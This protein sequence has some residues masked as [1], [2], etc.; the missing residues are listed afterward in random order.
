MTS[1]K[2]WG[3]DTTNCKYC[4]VVLYVSRNKDNKGITDFKE[5]RKS[6]IC[7]EEKLDHYRK[8]FINFAEDGV[9]GEM[10]RLYI[11]VNK[12]DMSII[13]KQLIHFLIDEEDFNLCSMNSRLA[14]IAA[15][16]ECA[17]EKKWMID[18]DSEFPD[19]LNKMMDEIMALDDTIEYHTEKTPHGYAIICNHGFDSCK[20]MNKWFDVATIKKD[21]LL[22]ADWWVKKSKEE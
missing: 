13:R 9:A 22:C 2:S 15:R 6:F 10:S 20:I 3:V 21:D 1:N 8:E 14:A 17:A 5:R 7:T 4:Y 11:S 19:Q 16:K 12:R 18:F